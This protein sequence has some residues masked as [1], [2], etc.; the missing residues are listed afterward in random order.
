MLGQQADGLHLVILLMKA[1]RAQLN[2]NNK[3]LKQRVGLYLW[4]TNIE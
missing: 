2:L 3:T 1:L 4:T